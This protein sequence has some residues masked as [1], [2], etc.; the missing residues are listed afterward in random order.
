MPRPATLAR[1]AAPFLL[2]LLLAGLGAACSFC[3]A[4]RCPGCWGR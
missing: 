2:C 3:W 1:R 4:R